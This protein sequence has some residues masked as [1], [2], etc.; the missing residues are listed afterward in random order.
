MP[1]NSDPTRP[2]GITTSFEGLDAVVALRGRIG[3]GAAFELG[4]SLDAAIDRHPLS[5][6]L[7]LTD[8][9]FIGPAATM[10]VAHAQKRLT[11]MGTQL[12]V[13]SP[14]ELINRLLDEISRSENKGL[15]DR[16]A[17][18]A[19]G[20]PFALTGIKLE[21]PAME[22]R[23]IMAMPTDP[24]VVDGALRLVVELARALVDGADGVSISLQ[25]HGRLSTVAASDQT[26]MEM[27]AD[28]YATGEG[29]CVDASLQGHRFYAESLQNEE[30][31]PNFTPQALGLGIRAILS[32]PLLAFRTPVGALN[33]YSRATEAF[34]VQ[35]QAAA[36]VFAQKASVILSDAGAA[37]TDTQLAFRYQEALRSRRAITLATGVLMEREG[38]DEEEAFRDLLRLSLY[39]GDPLREQANA[40]VRSSRQSELGP[41]FGLDE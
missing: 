40:I 24:E 19:G 38:V 28:Q 13:R 22:W 27:D 32:S 14:S 21:S 33:I 3:D 11:D 17:R 29:P 25:R 18:Q 34:D 36:G 26:I 1:I 16:S 4:V 37:V 30:R 20:M 41:E 12:T 31:W 7:D 2:F 39:H 10:A 9:D 35:A 8:L 6:V 23:G 5:I 15:A